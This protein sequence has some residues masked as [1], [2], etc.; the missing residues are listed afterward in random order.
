MSENKKNWLKVLVPE[1]V[2]IVTALVV[3][4]IGRCLEMDDKWIAAT[5]VIVFVFHGV[6]AALSSAISFTAYLFLCSVFSSVTCAFVIAFVAFLAAFYSAPVSVLTAAT[7]LIF[8][9]SAIVGVLS[10]AGV[11]CIV[12][13]DYKLPWRWLALAYFVEMSGIFLPLFLTLN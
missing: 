13:A 5:M 11:V 3:F 10:I 6:I 1:V 4:F 7:V 9:F 12:T 2:A 8:I